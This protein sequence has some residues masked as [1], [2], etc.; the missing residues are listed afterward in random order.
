M[1]SSRSVRRLSASVRLEL[2]TSSRAS[3]AR[4]SWQRR[5]LPLPR[6]PGV[7][8]WL[9]HWCLR[10]YRSLAG[11]AC[12]WSFCL[13]WFLSLSGALIQRD[14]RPA[15]FT[16]VGRP[17]TAFSTALIEA[18]AWIGAWMGPVLWCSH[19]SQ[20]VIDWQTSWRS[21]LVLLRSRA[22]YVQARTVG[23][24]L[25]LQIDVA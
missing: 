12:V 8:F 9:L 4:A 19:T 3:A 2:C 17:Q 14:Q 13:R 15:V 7:A 1:T 22:C 5:C 6:R 18:Q 21:G 24:E 23:L 25:E 11:V 16:H 10:L 20:K